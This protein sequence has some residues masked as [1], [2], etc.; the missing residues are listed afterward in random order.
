MHLHIGPDEMPTRV[1]S[2]EAA[3]Q[4]A[5][6]KMR[7]IVLKNH[8]YPT[9]PVAITAQGLV[10]EIKLFGS[11]CLDYEIGGL[12]VDTLERHTQFGAKI[13][14]IPTFSSTNSRAKMR[15]LGLNLESEGSPY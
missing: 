8:S 14:W 15:D 9:T 4:A 5:Y 11:I 10:P 1:D 2:I 3:E 12:N 13:V 7:A 6:V